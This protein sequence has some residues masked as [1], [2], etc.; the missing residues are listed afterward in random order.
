MSVV[1]FGRK[2]SELRRIARRLGQAEMAER[3]SG[4][5]AAARRA[6]QE[7]A[8]DQIRFDDV[9]NGVTGLRQGGGKRL[10][11]DRSAAVVQR[12]RRQIAAVHGI[13]TGGVNLEC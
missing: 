12:D 3:M 9:L 4:D 11:A 7:A 1:L 5:Q 2:Q 8:L 13:E 10:D 6:L